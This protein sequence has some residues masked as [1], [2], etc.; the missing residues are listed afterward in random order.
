M[1]TC[2]PCSSAPLPRCTPPSSSSSSTSSSAPRRSWSPS[3]SCSS[4]SPFTPWAPLPPRSRL[5]FRSGLTT[6][7][8]ILLQ[9]S[10]IWFFHLVV[11][12]RWTRRFTWFR[13]QERNT[14]H[15]LENG[16]VLLKHDIARVSLSLFFFPW[17][18]VYP[19]L[20]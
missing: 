1:R 18:D 10:P 6:L 16:V 13:S 5:P 11:S 12:S 2:R 17:I 19:S 20:L 3:C 7:S 15:L 9:S 14:L 4:I 8:L